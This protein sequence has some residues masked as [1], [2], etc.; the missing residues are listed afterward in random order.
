MSERSTDLRQRIVR[1][2]ADLLTSGGRDAVSTRSVSAA[3]GVQPPAIYRQ[4][5]DMQGLLDAAA[6]EVF[7]RYVRRK[8]KR[9][10]HEDPL[11]ELRH[12]WDQHVAFGLANAAA[13]SLLFG[14]VTTGRSPEVQT[15]SAILR[16]VVARVAESG[17]LR[18]TVEHAVELIHAGASGVTLSLLRHAPEAR[19]EQLSPSMRDLVLG[20]IATGPSTKAAAGPHR[21]AARAVALRSVLDES[22][23]AL[24]PAERDLLGEWLDRLAARRA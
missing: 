13:F 24:T 23:D 20:A 9:P 18:V 10:P 22:G 15:G 14:D 12:G 16:A 17:R 5:G 19:D 21:I 4:F 6:G 8:A 7:A 1:A 3:A 2:A 11:E